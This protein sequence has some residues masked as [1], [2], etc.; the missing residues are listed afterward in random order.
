[1]NTRS[2]LPRLLAIAALALA[3]AARGADAPPERFHG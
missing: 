1:M 3:A 2:P